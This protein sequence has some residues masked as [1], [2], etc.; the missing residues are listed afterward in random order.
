MGFFLSVLRDPEG[1]DLSLRTPSSIEKTGSSF[2]IL[3][4]LTL[5]VDRADCR[6]L[7]EV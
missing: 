3:K 7:Y 2:K 1:L 5:F 4:R 6:K